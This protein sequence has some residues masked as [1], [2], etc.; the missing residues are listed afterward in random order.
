VAFVFL[1]MYFFFLVPIDRKFIKRMIY[2][3]PTIFIVLIGAG[4]VYLSFVDTKG[5]D[6]F[7]KE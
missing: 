5:A 1:A 3:V 2:V 6:I 7:S 4:Y